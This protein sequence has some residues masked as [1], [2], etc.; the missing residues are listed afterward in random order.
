M[1][2]CKEESLL[3]SRE[4]IIT[5][6]QWDL[7]IQYKQRFLLNNAQ[8]SDIFREIGSDQLQPELFSSWVRSRNMKV[9]PY[10]PVVAKD[11]QIRRYEEI[12]KDNRAII[13]IAKPKFQLYKNIIVYPDYYLEIICKE[14]VSLLREETLSL[15]PF[16]SQG[17]TFSECTMGTNAH[18]L[19]MI[20]KNPVQLF[21]P[22]HYCV[23]L[24]H[25][26]AS[27]APILDKSR[28]A[29][30]SVILVQP[31]DFPPWERKMQDR[32]R[33]SLG[34][35]I[36]LAA[37]IKTEMLL[38]K[39]TEKLKNV[40]S[41]YNNCNNLFKSTLNCID[42]KILI[43]DRTGQIINCSHE[44]ASLF[45]LKSDDIG[46]KNITEYLDLNSN[47]IFL[48]AK[49]ESAYIKETFCIDSNKQTFV[50]DIYP[51]HDYSSE[52]PDVVILKLKNSDKI[53][54]QTIIRSGAETRF[55]FED[56]IG[57]SKAMQKAIGIGKRFAQSPEN[58]LLIG[59]SGTGKELFAQAIHNMYCPQRPF[60]AVNCAALPREL[61][62]SELF[63]YEGGSFT[64]AE[65]SGKPGKIELAKDG[66]LFLDE[67]GDMPLDLQAVL[68]RVLED[69]QVMRIG[70]RSH[71]KIEFRTIAATNKDLYTMVKEGRFR[72][73][74]YFRL[75][76]LPIALPPLR[77]RENDLKIIGDYIIKS[78]C[79]KI[80]KNALKIS[81]N[82][83]KIMN[84][85]NWPGNVRQLKNV[86]IYAINIAIGESIELK[87]LPD[88]I[89]LNSQP[90]LSDKVANNASVE[91]VLS[92]RK[93]EKAAIDLAMAYTQNSIADAADMLEISKATLYRKLREE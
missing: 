8:D 71:K 30:A 5:K 84:Q 82:A 77:K 4:N 35:V 89:V 23:E 41:H 70:G 14:E 74:L 68:L 62:E 88:Y 69:K 54:S 83:Q 6:E 52:Q 67:I 86:L 73:D 59:E 16:A 29:I 53:N 58:V 38:K 27:A 12:L 55:C 26:I 40:R 36:S 7:F 92:L 64:G 31:M 21:G 34:I 93:I 46:K 63:G 85:Y 56:I 44:C 3:N 39:T 33:Y 25:V 79:E 9:N 45:K 90:L 78:Y 43:I 48:T 22:E 91:E 2:I 17:T 32:L 80:G 49:G 20:L 60:M 81:A 61:I 75:A 65:R 76:V 11:L 18:T 1:I 15:P 13:D 42:E 28:E 24:E 87:D 37:A 66:T 10:H 72:E 19:S 51:V 57:E 47:I 50:V